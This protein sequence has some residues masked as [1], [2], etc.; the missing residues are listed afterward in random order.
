MPLFT[1]TFPA[2]DPVFIHLGPIEIRWYALGYI[3][4]LVLGAVYAKAL[5]RSRSL[6]IEPPGTA[7]DIDDLLVWV[8][9]G[10]IVG[11]RLGPIPFTLAGF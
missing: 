10:V 11:G 4:G 8:A 3:F 6:W 1:I 2:I 9:L 5:V 7:A